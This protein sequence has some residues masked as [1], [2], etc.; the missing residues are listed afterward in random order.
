MRLPLEKYSRLRICVAL[1]GGADSVC[2][3]HYLKE[4]GAEYHIE[5]SAL[6]C[7]HGIR[8]ERSLADLTF[9]ER[10]C[11]D[12]GIPLSVFRADVPARAQKNGRGLEEEGRAFRYECYRSV[13]DEGKADVVAT[14]H[15]KDD[16]A[17]TVLFRLIRG[18]SLGGLAA[19]AEREGIVRPMLEV[20]RTEI[21]EYARA[22]SLPFVTDES[23]FSDAF[24]RNFLRRN[25]MPRLEEAVSGATDHLTEFAERAARDDE[26]LQSL[27]REKIIRNGNALSFPLSL[28]APLFS[29][30]VVL[31]LKELGLER[32]YTQ[33]SVTQVAD[34]IK[35]QSGKR[36][37]LPRG[38][39]A[40][41]EGD[42][43][44]FLRNER[45]FEGEL[46]FALGK[47][48]FGEYD[49][50][51]GAEEEISERD[52]KTLYADLAKFPAGCVVRTRRTGDVFRPFGGS[53]KS[54]KEFL[55]D[56]K[57]PARLGHALPVVANGNR[58]YAVFG[59][60][61][62]DEVKIDSPAAPRF[63]LQISRAT[64]FSDKT[65]GGKFG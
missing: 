47:F 3:L 52:F 59:V 28:P 23:N 41:R 63:I 13:I 58:V 60:E 15:Q 53:D 65:E 35:K 39:V 31:C 9:V 49:I 34:L 21:E 19:I 26:F 14:A 36:A 22:Y 1:S 64:E 62:S 6:T 33:T 48:S 29:R 30:A 7:E 17:E 4:N 37:E 27:A 24:T 46:P 44:T 38:I 54:L 32:D 57:I 61:I 10:L 18:T 25:V 2:L 45:R 40:V 50:A 16:L 43:V 5:L 42:F 51:I 56:R 20:T 8:G 12:W 55:T 11:A